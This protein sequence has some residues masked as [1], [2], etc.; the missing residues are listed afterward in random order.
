MHAP[1]QIVRRPPGGSNTTGGPKP[2]NQ[3]KLADGSGS[4]CSI[5][6]PP[7]CRRSCAPQERV[8]APKAFQEIRG[9]VT[10]ACPA[11]RSCGA[12]R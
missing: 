4:H 7:T 8:M 11:D 5:P 9:T 3:Q 6:D 10:I 12:L 1:L 2:V